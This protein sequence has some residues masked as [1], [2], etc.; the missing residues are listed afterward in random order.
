MLNSSNGKVSYMLGGILYYRVLKKTTPVT[1][2]L[3]NHF[4][5][6]ITKGHAEHL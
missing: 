5:R 1:P 2:F 4:A 6:S 3:K